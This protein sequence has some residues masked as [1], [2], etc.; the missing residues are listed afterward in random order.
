MMTVTGREKPIVLFDGGCNFCNSTVN[1]IVRHDPKKNFEFFPFHSDDA[2]KL[3]NS[4]GRAENYSE[5]IV[6][7]ENEKIFFRSTASLRIARKLNRRISWVYIFI[8]IPEF[9]R[10]KIYDWIAGHRYSWFGKK[11]SCEIPGDDLKKA[12]HDS[13]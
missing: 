7:I 11:E 12:I 13:R 6:L 10:D 4:F 8:F 9:F 5:S 1:F 2:K 3:L